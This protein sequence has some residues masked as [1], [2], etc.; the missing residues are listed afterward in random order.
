MT[1]PRRAGPSGA[2]VRAWRTVRAH[3]EPRSAVLHNSLRVAIGLA[4]SVFLARTLGFSHA[5]W[6]V[7]GTLQV[8]RGSAL[9][10]GRPP[11]EPQEVGGPGHLVVPGFI[12]A[13]MHLE[14]SKL[15]VDEF[16]RLVL[17]FGTT[18]VVADPNPAHSRMIP[19]VT[20]VT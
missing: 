6:V 16:A 18:A 15:L 7:L 13:H 20:Y 2:L 9:G 3:L 12:D 10:T 14:S 17:P 19:G 8:L 11:Q 5:F 4:A 1:I